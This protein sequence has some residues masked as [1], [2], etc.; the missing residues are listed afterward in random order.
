MI[1]AI[2]MKWKSI[3]LLS[4]LVSLA[5]EVNAQSARI[6]GNSYLIDGKYLP[7]PCL[8]PTPSISMGIII[9]KTRRWAEGIATLP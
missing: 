6:V 4:L 1:A 2:A 5:G 9:W 7:E 3:L 8:S